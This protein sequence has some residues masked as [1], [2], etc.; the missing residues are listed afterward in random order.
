[1]K[2]SLKMIAEKLEERTAV[3]KFKDIYS[4]IR[5]ERPLFLNEETELAP[6]TLYVA[7][8]DAIPK[9]TQYHNGCA[10]LIPGGPDTLI[11]NCPAVILTDPSCDVL[12]LY[13]EV[14]EIFDRFEQWEQRLKEALQ[15]SSCEASL[16]KIVLSPEGILD[17]PVLLCGPDGP[18]RERML[19]LQKGADI[20]RLSTERAPF[21]L[22]SPDSSSRFMIRNLFAGDS[23]LYHLLL[24]EEER[25]FRETDFQ[26]LDLLAVY[27]ETI[28]RKEY[29]IYSYDTSLLT[30]LFTGI[31]EGE[32][33]SSRQLEPELMRIRWSAEDEFALLYTDAPAP[34]FRTFPGVFS[35]ARGEKTLLLANLS[36]MP[37][38]L[39]Q[40]KAFFGGS[41]FHAGVSNPF[42]GLENL[43][44][45]CRQAET[46]YQLRDNT[47][48]MPFRDCVLSYLIRTASLEFAPEDLLSPVYIRLK[49]HDRLN[50][51]EYLK[52]LQEYLLHNLNAVQTAA[53]LFTHRA[54]IIYRI[55]RICEI[56][57]TDLKKPDELLHLTLSFKLDRM[58]PET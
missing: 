43:Q 31:L 58:F 8:A 52:T 9:I 41:S 51:T 15:E 29:G 42:K 3:L 55:K 11:R 7:S 21:I 22:S 20:R 2:L 35:F 34:V 26:Y 30:Q 4:T 53:A 46:A 37:D 19:S 25:D 39:S 18:G 28:L 49:E 13:N 57:G 50:R 54:T 1:M 24:Q 17:S 47:V 33:V 23:V 16:E 6:D 48:F 40:L 32:A 27:A 14:N 45:A 38:C 56:G 10:L 44:R 12:D 36:Q 5:L